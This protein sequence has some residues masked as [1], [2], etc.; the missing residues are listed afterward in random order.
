MVFLLILLVLRF[1]HAR[2]DQTKTVVLAGDNTLIVGC[3]ININ[4][5]VYD[6]HPLTIDD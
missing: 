6:L 2:K 1:S 3:I 5:N 4:S